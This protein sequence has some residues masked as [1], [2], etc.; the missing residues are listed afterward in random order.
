MGKKS[1]R[2][3]SNK[4]PPCYHGCSTKKEFNSGEHYKILEA[5]DNNN[6]GDVMDFYETY[7]HVM[8][9]PSFSCFIIAHVTEDYLKGKDNVI[10]FHRLLL[11]L[12]IRYSIIPIHEGK[13]VGPETEYFR[14]LNKYGRDVHTER[15]RINCMAREIPCDCM[16]EKRIEAKSMVKS[17]VCYCCRNEFLKKRML[18]CKGC[19]RAQYCSK[20]CSIKHWPHHKE[21]CEQKRQI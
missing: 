1:K 20:E 17:A 13:D 14:N 9:D 11:F 3:N 10:L 5:W 12:S 8:D 15:G 21:M 19:D 6:K 2:K 16:E 7:K 4:P 18:R